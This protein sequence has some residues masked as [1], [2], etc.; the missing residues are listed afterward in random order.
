MIGN[1]RCAVQL[2]WPISAL[3]A[4]SRKPLFEGQKHEQ[5]LEASFGI[6]KDALAGI[7][8]ASETLSTL[9]LMSPVFDTPNYSTSVLDSAVVLR[10]SHER[11]EFLRRRS[12]CSKFRSQPPFDCTFRKLYR[13]E[14]LYHNITTS[15]NF[16]R[17]KRQCGRKEGTS[18]RD[19]GQPFASGKFDASKK[20]VAAGT[21]HRSEQRPT[22]LPSLAL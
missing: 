2:Y 13:K 12:F 1:R 19:S 6:N 10:R 22:Q 18:G 21:F 8:A 5:P 9:S 15:S 4:S 20:A 17:K 14:Q 3:S 7:S 11:R 16:A